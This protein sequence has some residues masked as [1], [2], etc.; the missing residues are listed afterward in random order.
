MLCFPL[1]LG[2]NTTL[3]KTRPPKPGPCFP[4]SSP[5]LATQM[6]H[7]PSVT[8]HLVCFDC[9]G[10][11]ASCSLCLQ[12]PFPKS[13]QGAVFLSL[14]SQ[15][16][17]WLLKTPSLPGKAAPPCHS[18]ETVTTFILI[19]VCVSEMIYLLYVSCLS[20]WLEYMPLAGNYS[21][22]FIALSLEPR[23]APDT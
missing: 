6:S 5:P 20:S 14:R 8:E 4:P 1:S 16:Q 22:L 3:I 23:T 13:L 7:W 12:D 11:F 19:T 10:L 17:G 18:R 2:W 21:I 9:K 15:L